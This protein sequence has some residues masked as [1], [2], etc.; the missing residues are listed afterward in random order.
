MH[1]VR[2]SYIILFGENIMIKNWDFLTCFQ[3]S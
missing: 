1:F 3:Y 2:I